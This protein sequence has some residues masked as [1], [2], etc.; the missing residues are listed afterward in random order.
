[1]HLK[2]S[3]LLLIILLIMAFNQTIKAQYI[4]QFREGDSIVAGTGCSQGF[5]EEYRFKPKDIDSYE[6]LIEHFGTDRYAVYFVGKPLD[7]IIPYDAKY[8][9]IKSKNGYSE[10][11]DYI[12][13]D[14]NISYFENTEIIDIDTA[15]IYYVRSDDRIPLFRSKDNVY[16]RGHLLDKLNADKTYTLNPYS[17]NRTY[18]FSDSLVIYCNEVLMENA[19]IKTFNK[20]KNY[21][22]KR[23]DGKQYHFE[24]VA[25]SC[26]K[27]HFYMNGK[28]V[29]IYPDWHTTKM[30]PDS[31]YNH[32]YITT[33][34]SQYEIQD[35]NKRPPIDFYLETKDF[36]R[37]TKGKKLNRKTA[38]DLT[39]E[40]NLESV[41]AYEIN[42]YKN[43]KLVATQYYSQDIE[44][45][46]IEDFTKNSCVGDGFHLSLDDFNRIRNEGKPIKYRQL[47]G[48]NLEA[49]QHKIAELKNNP[50][51]IT[52]DTLSYYYTLPNKKGKRYIETIDEYKVEAD[53]AKKI[54]TEMYKYKGVCIL[55]IDRDGGKKIMGYD[56]FDISYEE[57]ENITEELIEHLMGKGNYF[58]NKHMVFR[59]INKKDLITYEV[60]CTEDA[61][62]NVPK[63]NILFP[64]QPV[65]HAVSW[66]EK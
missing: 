47:I 60:F 63:E 30:F 57:K 44:E 8:I 21:L 34:I 11:I 19:D 4:S 2:K 35:T 9:F 49:W 27:S 24:E 36:E 3:K 55:K 32:Q 7:K 65:L 39:T 61:V 52:L 53:T 46:D 5:Y 50:N 41:K 17:K 56:I 22:E 16:F 59:Y 31:I 29:T 1:M 13:T 51:V 66:Q 28:K 38:L 14:G 33:F 15:D 6:H 42:T 20:D 25:N 45:I 37:L 58:I 10:R 12:V 62:K 23:F 40:P 48:M 54:F 43:K 64:W 18:Y 26:D